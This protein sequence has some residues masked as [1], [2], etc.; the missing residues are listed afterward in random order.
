MAVRS[1]IQY[2]QDLSSKPKQVY[3][4]AERVQD[5]TKQLGIANGAK[6]IASLYDMQTDPD[7]IE[8]MTFKSPTTG[9]PVGLSFIQPNPNIPRFQ[10]YVW[11]RVPI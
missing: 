8:K 11:Y 2:L 3:I 1:G 9:D 6:A 4:N 5:V 7:L 10:S